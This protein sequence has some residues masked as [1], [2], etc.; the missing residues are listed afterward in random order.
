VNL[1]C[2]NIHIAKCQS[3]VIHQTNNIDNMVF[4]FHDSF[5]DV[6]LPVN[7]T[8]NSSIS[9]SSFMNTGFNC[10]KNSK[11]SLL[12]FTPLQQQIINFVFL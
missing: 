2:F 7:N 8:I 11:V 5:F 1:K 9:N 6:S 3:T 10:Q 12:S 4:E